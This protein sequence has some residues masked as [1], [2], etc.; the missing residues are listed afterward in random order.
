MDSQTYQRAERFLPWNLQQHIFNT[1]IFPYWSSE[2]LYYFHSTKE[3]KDLI[4]IDIKTG[5]K[6]NILSFKKLVKVLSFEIQHEIY[7]V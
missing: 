2:A 6:E 7:G 3:E 1:T 4:R 5:K